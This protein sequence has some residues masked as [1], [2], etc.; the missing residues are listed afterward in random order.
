MIASDKTKEEKYSLGKRIIITGK[1]LTI[2]RAGNY[3]SIPYTDQ[4][5]LTNLTKENNLLFNPISIFLTN[6][7]TNTTPRLN[8]FTLGLLPSINASILIQLIITISPKLARLKKEEG[9]YG[10]RKINQYTRFLTLFLAIIQAIG[11]T[12]NIKSF[13]FDWNFRIASQIILSLISGSMITLWF[14]ELI[15]RDGLK[16]GSSLLICFNII[17]NLPDPLILF[18]KLFNSNPYNLVL[19]IITYGFII[20]G[21]V[22]QNEGILR[23]PL[24]SPNQRLRPFSPDEEIY[25]TKQNNLPLR[26]N[27]SGI[28]PLIITSGI[29]T[30]VSSIL[31]NFKMKLPT[32]DFLFSNFIKQIIFSNPDILNKIFFWTA[33]TLLIFF[34]TKFY[35]KIMLNP[36]D[37]SEQLRKKSFI[38][39][40]ISPGI[41]TEKYLNKTI[42]RLAKLNGILFM[43][44]II[45]SEIVSK[46]L[47]LQNLSGFSL[48]SQIILVNVIIET[49]RNMRMIDLSDQE[50]IK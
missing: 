21:C 49:F 41:E 1:V 20:L 11:L 36:K 25:L 15:T 18:S 16:N 7:S 23:I 48:S 9:D 2:I 34:F 8:L 50:L 39:R 12:Y 31:T 29:M 10:Q 24:I 3:I 35:S 33:Y 37:I 4:L 26:V 14:S 19:L 38:I 46:F 6:F 27:Q 17:S 13:V 42:D 30:L 44:L 40:G 5:L 47:N 22:Y 43:S 32:S 28:M 45:P